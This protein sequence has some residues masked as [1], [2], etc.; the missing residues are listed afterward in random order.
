MAGRNDPYGGFNFLVEIDGMVAAGF[1][2]VSGIGVEITPIEYREGSD[3]SHGVRK[4]PGL[5]KYPNITLKRGVTVSRELWDWAKTGMTGPVQR[6]NGSI[7]LLDESGQEAIRWK[8][9]E[10]WVC[11]YEGPALTAGSNEVA[12][13]S[14]EICH[15]GIE[16][17]Q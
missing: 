2:S 3:K 15:E 4:L 1:S 7:I 8:F 5:A 16:L 17:D 11:K 6:R 10:G 14:I 13:E 12:I 9:V